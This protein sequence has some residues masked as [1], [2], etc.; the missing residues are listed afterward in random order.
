MN[1]PH[2]RNTPPAVRVEYL[3]D[4]LVVAWKHYLDCPTDR[5]RRTMSLVATERM[6]AQLA[7]VPPAGP[8]PVELEVAAMFPD[9]PVPSTRDV[10]GLPATWRAIELRTALAAAMLEDGP[11][12]WG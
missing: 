1:Q 6:K 10:A 12:G 9:P 8:D 2:R 11:G 7:M 4:T 5:A 3:T